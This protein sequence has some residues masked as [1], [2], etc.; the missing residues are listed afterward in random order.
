MTSLT[1]IS[2]QGPLGRLPL[3]DFGDDLEV[4]VHVQGSAVHGNE[5]I[6]QGHWWAVKREYVDLTSS[7]LG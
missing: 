7:A 5:S 6:P 1:V 2:P 3:D 4:V